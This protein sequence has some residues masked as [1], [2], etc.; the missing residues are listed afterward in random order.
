MIRRPMSEAHLASRET[1]MTNWNPTRRDFLAS[2]ASAPLAGLAPPE[3]FGAAPIVRFGLV[4]D[5]HYAEIDA[6]GVRAYRESPRKLE[7]CVS[8]MND[9]RVD[10]LVELG[11]FKDQDKV[12]VEEKTLG[13]LRRIEAIYARFNGPRYHVLGNHD[14]D[15]LSKAQFLSVAANSGIPADRSYYAFDRAGIRFIVLDANFSTVGSPYDHGNFDWGDPNVPASEL[16]WLGD[17]LTGA[18]RSVIFVHQQLDGT[19]AY[20]VKNAAAVRE[21][22]ERSGKVLAVFQGHRHE[23]GYSTINGIHYYTLKGLIEGAG[24]EDNSYAIVEADAQ[25]NLTVTGYKRAVSTGLGR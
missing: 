9:Q 17:Q 15:S 2:V 6:A 1:T 7:E 23:G 20:Y 4:T 13:Y 18:R 12:P 14:M 19:G 8:L 3:A 10:F 25:F 22:L 5:I 24:A 11:D 16:S 21:V